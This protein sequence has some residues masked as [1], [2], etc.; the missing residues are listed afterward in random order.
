MCNLFLQASHLLRP[1]S[2]MPQQPFSSLAEYFSDVAKRR[3]NNSDYS[4]TDTPDFQIAARHAR[5]LE[6]IEQWANSQHSDSFAS[7][8]IGVAKAEVLRLLREEVVKP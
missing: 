2:Y 1:E 6:R 3:A 4:I 8:G 7:A 5:L